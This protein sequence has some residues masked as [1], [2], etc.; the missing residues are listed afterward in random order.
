[1]NYD[2]DE[3]LKE[4]DEFRNSE[5]YGLATDE[6]RVALNLF[7]QAMK[8]NAPAD[9]KAAFEEVNDLAEYNPYK[10][11]LTAALNIINEK[12][13]RLEALDVA[14]LEIDDFRNNRDYGLATDESRVALNLFDQAMITSTPEDIEAALEEANDL[15]D[16]NPYK[17]RLVSALNTLKS[18]LNKS[19]EPITQAPAEPAQ[20]NDSDNNYYSASIPVD[21]VF[22]ENSGIDLSGFTNQGDFF[23]VNPGSYDIGMANENR[24]SPEVVESSSIS[25]NINSVFDPKPIELARTIETIKRLYTNDG[26][27]KPESVLASFNNALATGNSA[28]IGRTLVEVA[29]LGDDNLYKAPLLS[30]LESMNLVVEQKNNRVHQESTEQV[31]SPRGEYKT[32]IVS[33]APQKEPT[34]NTKTKEERIKLL[35]TK[36]QLLNL[37]KGL[38]F[39]KNKVPPMTP[40]ELITAYAYYKELSGDDEFTIDDLIASVSSIKEEEETRSRS[41]GYSLVFLLGLLTSIIIL[42]III[43]GSFISL[44]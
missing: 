13:K 10:E 41:R 28:D 21:N 44:S 40:E 30:A 9:I 23:A 2:L 36:L 39:K 16:Y 38:I 6:S 25:T 43:I 35:N 17:E 42:G 12:Y 32:A 3:L 15:A 34:T 8:T 19:D 14:F 20:T 29:K 18:S 4:I 33:K 24:V 26:V 11:K 31:F 22:M 5:D 1:M 7:D 27:V 37:K